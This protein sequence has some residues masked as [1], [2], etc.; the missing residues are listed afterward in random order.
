MNRRQFLSA[1]LGAGLSAAAAAIL[2]AC[3]GPP[4]PAPS[5]R[6]AP[7]ASEPGTSASPRTG[8][9]SSAVPAQGRETAIATENRRPGHRGWDLRGTGDH[10]AAEV[11]L[12]AASAA[13][14]SVLTVHLASAAVVDLEWYRLGWY[15]GDGGRQVRIDRAVRAS[16][17]GPTRIDPDTGMTEADSRAALSFVIPPDWPTGVYLLV[18]RPD[19]GTP[20]GATFTIRA[21]PEGPPAPVL[22]VSAATTWQAYNMWGGADLYDA[23]TADTPVDAGGRRATQVSFDRPQVQFQGVGYMPRWELPFIRWL[24]RKGRAVEYVVDVDLELHPEVIAGRRLLV[25]AGHHEYWSRPM[26]TTLETAIASGV[27]VAFL[28][29]NEVYWQVR[30]EPSP[31]GPARRVVCFKS[32]AL[33]PLATSQPDL[34]TCRW[35]EPPVNDPEAAVVGQMY[36]HIVERVADW[37][38][39]GADHWLY[40]GTG[41]RNGDRIVNLVG[42]EYDTFYPQYAPPGTRILAASSVVPAIRA[43]PQGGQ[44]SNPSVHNA[45]IY[46]AESGATVFAA[47]TFQWSWAL[48]EYGDRAYRGVATPLDERVA[49][50][51]KNLFD[52]LG[53]GPS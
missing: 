53:D 43:E 42:Q 29:A 50:M 34:A 6:R 45:T 3:A 4:T 41:L 7:E 30:F 28:S 22:F 25:F 5:N 32:A 27:N 14:G 31:L 36:G 39:A 26:R 40:A 51:T 2:A 18:A 48:D 1:T 15:G 46:T 13:P 9:E 33:D 19:I 24:E 38:V 49:R 12:D 20:G 37:V 8:P 35:R 10:P 17:P 44:P 11:F 23:S 47:G 16:A 21:S 52:R